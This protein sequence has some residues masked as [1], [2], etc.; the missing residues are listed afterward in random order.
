MKRTVLTLYRQKYG[1]FGPTLAS[2]KLKEHDGQSV[3]PVTLWRWLLEEGLW[4]RRRRRKAHRSRRERRSCLGE[5]VQM[6]GSHHDWFEGR[7][8]WCVLMVLVD[9]ATGKIFARFYEGET[10]AACFDVFGRYVRKHGLPRALYVDRDSIYR[11]DRQAT[12]EEELRAESPLTRL[13]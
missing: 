12:V 7:G 5:L 13:D 4:A 6:D 10:T 2:E 3:K 8:P 11:S 1:D 9:D